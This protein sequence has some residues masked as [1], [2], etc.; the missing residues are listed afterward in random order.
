MQTYTHKR[1]LPHAP[2]IEDIVLE[3]I[4][5][6]LSLTCRYNGHTNTFYSVAEHCVRLSLIEHKSSEQWRLMHDASEAYLGDII[7]P[8]KLLLRSFRPIEQNFHSLIAQKFNLN[9][10]DYNHQVMLAEMILLATEARDL[11]NV[12]PALDWGMKTEP[13]KEVIKPW[14]WMRAKKE[15]LQRAKELNIR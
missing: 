10:K 4:A 7:T 11:M 1:I 6:S 15:F 9:L 8:V 3:D 12:N 13:L 5:H 2:K 14:P